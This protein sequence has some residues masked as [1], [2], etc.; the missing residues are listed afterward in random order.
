MC[1]DAAGDGEPQSV[2]PVVLTRFVCAEKAFEETVACFLR[3]RIAGVGNR[4]V[5]LLRL[6]VATNHDLS[7][8]GGITDRVVQKDGQQILNLIFNTVNIHIFLNIRRDA[9]FLLIRNTFHRINDVV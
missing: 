5:K 7:G 4:E 6:Q 2:V 9:D 8:L 1:Y 3:D